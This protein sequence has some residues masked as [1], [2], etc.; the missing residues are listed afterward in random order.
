MRFDAVLLASF[1]GPESPDEV[2]PFL[3]RVTAGRGVTRE[4]LDGVAQ[5][6]L[7]LGGVSPINAQNR[8]LITALE[9]ELTRR[10][11]PQRIYWG[12]RNSAPFF[13]EAL[14]RCH[15]DG[16]RRVLAVATSAYSSYSGCRQYRE[17]LAQ[18]LEESGL[19]DDLAIAKIRPY[20]DQP[21]FIERFAAGVAQALGD[22]AHRGIDTVNI[23]VIF[24]TH[25]IP[26]SMALMSG[27]AGARADARPG[28]YESQ[29]LDV[30]TRVMRAAVGN[31]SDAPAWSLA[32][33]SRSGPPQLPWLEPDINTALA[34]LASTGVTSVIVAPIGFVSDHVEVIWDLDHDAAETAQHLG[35]HL[36]RVPTPGTD[37][38][39]VTALADLVQEALYGRDL[40]HA[41]DWATLC[42][43]A[44]CPNERADLPVVPAV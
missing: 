14:Q 15:A 13:A 3:E 7:D 31:E 39:F 42:T 8:Q 26:E 36:T 40:Q 19:A 30:A 29:H 34:D 10:G 35:L 6:Y 11:A 9:E 17:N 28:A 20:Y 38:D 33:Q 18:A 32:F 22:L 43:G 4:R 1:G 25:S 27:P 2:L 41:P 44:C 5:H 21:G 12:N 23:H 16:H 24:T 37:P